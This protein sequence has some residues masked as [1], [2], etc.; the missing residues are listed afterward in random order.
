M[1]TTEADTGIVAGRSVT[2]CRKIA[3]RIGLQPAD[4]EAC[5][6]DFAA[7]MTSDVGLRRWREEKSSENWLGV[8]A[9]NYVY[10][11]CGH[12]RNSQTHEISALGLALDL[13]A[14]QAHPPDLQALNNETRGQLEAAITKLEEGCRA[15]VTQR[16]L[17]GRSPAEISADSGI[18]SKAIGMRI[19]R[20]LRKLES[21]LNL[22]GFDADEALRLLNRAA[23]TEAILPVIDL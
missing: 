23:H 22:S 8:C 6:V 10:S 5:A 7:K 14:V 18:S 1:G 20:G 4:A 13:A 16:F 3:L 17:E 21:I 9:T 11:Y 2:I 19:T 15:V 12:L